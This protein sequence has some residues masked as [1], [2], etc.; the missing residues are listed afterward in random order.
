MSDHI[1]EVLEEVALESKDASHKER[2]LNLG[3][4]LAANVFVGPES[5]CNVLSF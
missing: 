2:L 3:R 4:F 5:R 1:F